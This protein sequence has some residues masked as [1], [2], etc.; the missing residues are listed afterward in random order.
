MSDDNIVYDIMIGKDRCSCCNK[1]IKNI[2]VYNN[3]KYGYYCFM[4]AI[5]KH[6]DKTTSKEKPLST[7]ICELMNNYIKNNINEYSNVDDFIINFF[8]EY[9]DDD[10]LN[11]NGEHKL[12]NSAIKIN[13]KN[14][15]VYQ[16][17]M[18]NDY[19]MMKFNT[20]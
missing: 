8:N 7:E 10:G 14:I 9:I 3:K 5:G 2:Y 1:V 4:D 17:Y 13:N 19:L 18:I 16:Q 6:I 15:P 11:K 20:K 12:W